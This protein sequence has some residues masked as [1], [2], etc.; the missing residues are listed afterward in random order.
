MSEFISKLTAFGLLLF[1][2]FNTHTP[3][4]DTGRTPFFPY[5]Q[6][7]YKPSKKSGVF[8]QAS[9][10]FKVSKDEQVKVDVGKNF[11]MYVM[12][13]AGKKVTVMYDFNKVLVLGN[14]TS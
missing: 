7:R 4:K 3:K 11:E 14:N 2:T 9:S 8:L 10:T 12:R 13:E 5:L 1:F 6:E